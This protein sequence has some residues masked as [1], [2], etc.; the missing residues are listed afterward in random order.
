ME[1]KGTDEDWLLGEFARTKETIQANVIIP[2][3]D[4]V[5]G[6]EEG[7]QHLHRRKMILSSTSEDITITSLPTKYLE[8]EL[9]K[10]EQGIVQEGWNVRDAERIVSSMVSSI[11][12]MTTSDYITVYCSTG[13]E[14][15]EFPFPLNIN[16]KARQNYIDQE[17]RDIS[18]NDEF[19]ERRKGAWSSYFVG[20]SESR[21]QACH[22]MREILTQLLDEFAKEDDVKRTPWWAWDTNAP[23]GVS[24]RQKLRFFV[25]GEK[26][27]FDEEKISQ[28]EQLIDLAYKAHSDVI[29]MAHGRIALDADPCRAALETLEDAMS[30]LLLE[31]RGPF[32]LA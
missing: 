9:K 19:V 2:A 25:Y 23:R 13:G 6:L 8:K 1:N 21:K 14:S 4:L 18:G 28:I 26:D 27:S 5:K 10:V 32:T 30:M 16:R 20:D 15:W 17:L 24:K 3:L 29:A 7:E 31:R 11:A 12:G 22:S